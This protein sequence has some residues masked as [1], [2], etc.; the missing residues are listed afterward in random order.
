MI[1]AA[2]DP[3]AGHLRIARRRLKPLVRDQDGFDRQ[4]LGRAE[5]QLLH[6][7]RRRVCIY[8]DSQKDH[9]SIKDACASHRG[10]TL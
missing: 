10:T 6:V 8:P 9:L 1:R 2:I 5:H 4:P 7:L 3:D